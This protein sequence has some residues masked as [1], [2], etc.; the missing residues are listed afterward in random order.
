[1]YSAIT[2]CL[3]CDSKDLELS[4]DLNSQPLAN[5]Y[6]ENANDDEDSFPLGINFCKNCT[7]IQLTHAVD[8]D[9]SIQTKFKKS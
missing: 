4:L 6:L 9:R 8:P 1:M 7:H 5:S 2:K 3:C